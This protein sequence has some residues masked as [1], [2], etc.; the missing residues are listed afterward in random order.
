MDK[1]MESPCVT[2]KRTDPQECDNKECRIWQRWFVNR[3]EQLRR[4]FL[5]EQDPC[6]YCPWPKELCVEDCRHKRL[7]LKERKGKE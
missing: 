3:W 2:C 6:T 7:W 5:K 4:E 1:N